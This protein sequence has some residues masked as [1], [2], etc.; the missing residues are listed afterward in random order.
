MNIR[1]LFL[2]LLVMLLVISC[3]KKSEDNPIEDVRYTISGAVQLGMHSDAAVTIESNSIDITTNNTGEYTINE[4]LSGDMIELRSYGA[5]FNLNSATQTTTKLELAAI[6]PLKNGT[7]NINLL[8]TLSYSR[9]KRLV[10]EG[11][12]LSA[13]ITKAEQEVLRVFRVDSYNI[14]TFTNIDITSESVSSATLLAVTVL[15][16]NGRNDNQLS[17]IIS[18]ISSEL[19]SNGELSLSTSNELFGNEQSISILHIINGLQQ[20]YTINNIENV[21]IPAFYNYLDLDN[22]GALDH[23]DEIFEIYDFSSDDTH[24]LAIEGGYGECRVFANN[25]FN[26]E[27]SDKWLTVSKEPL[28]SGIYNIKWSAEINNNE[29]RTATLTFTSNSGVL[30]SEMSVKQL[31]SFKPLYLNINYYLLDTPLEEGDSVFV[32]GTKRKTYFSSSKEQLYALAPPSDV[33]EVIFPTDKVVQSEG[34][35][36]Y[37][38]TFDSEVNRNSSLTYYGEV[39]GSDIVTINP[40][41]A[42]IEVDFSAVSDIGYMIITA[43][44]GALLSGDILYNPNDI[45]IKATSTNGSNSVRVN[46]S[47]DGTKCTIA[48][49]PQQIDSLAISI[50]DKSNNFASTHTHNQPSILYPSSKLSINVK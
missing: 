31:S 1:S 32:N 46:I 50:Y 42:L 10:A 11:E 29:E 25:N 17:A 8:T 34:N 3:K 35:S 41:V 28:E 2:A 36:L 30:L 26:V 20:L 40:A 23:N 7:V 18:K 21:S 38:V 4:V 24:I 37:R 44:S 27:S 39:S 16:Q 33:R 49:V 19:E 15:L 47:G 22:D 14:N 45:T 43:N 6:A 48:V 13:A 12:S 5:Y 9:I